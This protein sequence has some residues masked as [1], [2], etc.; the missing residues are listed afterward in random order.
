MSPDRSEPE[1]VFSQAGEQWVPRT[2]Y[3]RL[4]LERDEL[5]TLLGECRD[6]IDALG[7]FM[8]RPMD[9]LGRLDV[10]LSR[11]QQR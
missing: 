9:L 6:Y 7:D 2:E 3:T 8:A 11:E 10:A 4:K 5:R 1:R